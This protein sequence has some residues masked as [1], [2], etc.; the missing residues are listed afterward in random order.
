MPGLPVRC[1]ALERNKW[2]N[3][4]DV[5][6]PR[7]PPVSGC[8]RAGGDPGQRHWKYWKHWSL[9][10]LYAGCSKSRRIEHISQPHRPAHS[11]V[12]ASKFPAHVCNFRP[13]TFAAVSGPP[14][15]LVFWRVLTESRRL[16]NRCCLLLGRRFQSSGPPSLSPSYGIIS[17]NWRP[18]FPSSMFR[19]PII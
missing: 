8:H 3:C 7:S 10:C 15:L 12:L 17:S 18:S 16:Q 11:A 5:C 14:L 1:Q 19:R 2:R 13:L 6:D 9:S 4:A